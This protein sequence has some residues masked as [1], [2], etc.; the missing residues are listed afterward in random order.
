MTDVDD[1]IALTNRPERNADTVVRSTVS[2]PRLGHGAL[3]GQDLREATQEPGVY[4]LDRDAGGLHGWATRRESNS[5]P[6]PG[7]LS[8]MVVPVISEER[9]DMHQAPDLI[10]THALSRLRTFDLREFSIQMI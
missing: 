10:G 9:A 4:R 7:Q 1:G 6:D 5:L 3:N 8:G 2:D